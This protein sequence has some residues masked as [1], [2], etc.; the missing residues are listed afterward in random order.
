[1]RPDGR[2]PLLRPCQVSTRI[3]N[4]GGEG[5]KWGGDRYRCCP[6]QP[7][8]QFQEKKNTPAAREDVGPLDDA[9]CLP[10]FRLTAELTGHDWRRCVSETSPQPCEPRIQLWWVKLAE[11][12]R[13]FTSPAFKQMQLMIK[14]QIFHKGHWLHRKF[15][16]LFFFNMTK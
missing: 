7:T 16:S 5:R 15:P 14:Q 10:L 8:W 3:L 2:R 13:Q 1:M 12:P 4:E 9:M 6:A 11:V